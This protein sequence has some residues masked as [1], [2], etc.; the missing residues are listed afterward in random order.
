MKFCPHCGADLSRYMSVEQE[1]RRAAPEVTAVSNAGPY[2]QDALWKELHG[3]ALSNAA[4]PDAVQVVMEA[5]RSAQPL[6][7][8]GPAQTVVHVLFDR[9]VSLSG[10][11]IYSSVVQGDDRPVALERM[12]RL[13]YQLDGGGQVLTVDHMPVPPVY[14]IVEYW[15]GQRQHKRWHLSRPVELEVSRNGNPFFIDENMMA[16]GAVWEDSSKLEHAL[17]LLVEWLSEGAANIQAAGTPL[18]L[19]LTEHG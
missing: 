8:E 13:G 6:F 18:V 2:N 11:A 10:G 15:G 19:H 9:Q 5:V 7:K 14:S 1:G 3:R 17:H 4:E 16:F 12:K